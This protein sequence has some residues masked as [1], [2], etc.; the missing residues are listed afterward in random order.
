MSNRFMWK[1]G[2]VTITKKGERMRALEEYLETH[3][4]ECNV[5][6]TKQGNAY[7]CSCGLTKARNVFFTLSSDNAELRSENERLKS[8]MSEA[9]SIVGSFITHPEL[10]VLNI[11]RAEKWRLVYFTGIVKHGGKE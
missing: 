3:K 10:S 6:R 8:G 1:D 11:A 9:K 7:V 4:T 2:D 5:Y